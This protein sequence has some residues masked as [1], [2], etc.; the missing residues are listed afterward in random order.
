[1]AKQDSR[2]ILVWNKADAA[3][4][5]CP[6]GALPVS[7]ATG[8][9]FH[10]LEEEL[11]KRIFQDTPAR[12]DGPVIDSLRQKNLLERALSG[13]EKVREGIHNGLPVDVLAMDLAEVLQALGEITGE[14]SSADIMEQ[15][16][17]KFC[18]GK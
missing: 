1:M 5:P 3:E 11:K 12:R 8:A 7:A 4:M 2:R 17:S 16:F 15:M 18:V 10:L 14:V 13:V 9:G 6:D